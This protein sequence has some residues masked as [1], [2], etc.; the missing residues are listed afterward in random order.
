MLKDRVADDLEPVRSTI[1]S[2][3][4][5]TGAG[6]P[7]LASECLYLEQRVAKSITFSM[8]PAGRF[9]R[10]L[11]PFLQAPVSSSNDMMVERTGSRSSATRSII[12]ENSPLLASVIL[13]TGKLAT[14]RLPRPGTLAYY[15]YYRSQNVGRRLV[16]RAWKAMKGDPLLVQGP[17]D[18]GALTAR[19]QRQFVLETLDPDNMVLGDLI[20][21]DKLRVL[22]RRTLAGSNAVFGSASNLMCAEL[23]LKSVG[24]LTHL[25]V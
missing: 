8:F 24:R 19:H 9:T 22:V 18:Y 2:L 13:D 21:A 12:D 25:R 3:L 23:W 5:E 1:M 20:D 11:N 16:N 7:L 17:Y 6:D 4:D 10:V 15:T 14:L